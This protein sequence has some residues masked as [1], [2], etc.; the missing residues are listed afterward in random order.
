[1]MPEDRKEIPIENFQD[2]RGSLSEHFFGV[3]PYKLVKILLPAVSRYVRRDTPTA[4]SDREHFLIAV[5][6]LDL[7]KAFELPMNR[8]RLPMSRIIDDE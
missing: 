1:M 4:V 2:V 8:P 5:C 3:V 7:P 6:T